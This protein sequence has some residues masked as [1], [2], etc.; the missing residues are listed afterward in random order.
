MRWRSARGNRSSVSLRQPVIEPLYESKPGWWIAKE[1]SKRLGLADYFPWNT[2]E[3]KIK[4]QCSLWGINYDEL[5]KVGTIT[6]PDTANPFITPLNPARIQ[7]RIRQDRAVQQ[8][9]ERKGL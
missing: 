3:D 2:Y 6:I 7:N 4:S 8:G 5:K 9:A 1:L